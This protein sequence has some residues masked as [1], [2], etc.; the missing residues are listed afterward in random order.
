M[1]R[2]DFVVPAPPVAWHRPQQTKRGVT[3][4]DKQDVDYQALI[5]GYA[6]QAIAI[7]SVEKQYRWL[8]DGEFALSLGFHVHDLRRRDIDNLEKNVLDGMTG[9]AY[10]DDAQVVDVSKFKRLDRREPR[11]E[12]SV[13]SVSGYL[14]PN[15]SKA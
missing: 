15:A 4:K 5:A 8:K 2:I 1:Q 10:H 3:Y 14:K 12:L 7:W 13:R 11:V 9:V 6:Q